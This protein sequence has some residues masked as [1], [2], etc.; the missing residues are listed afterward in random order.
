[1]F[2]AA[3]RRMEHLVGQTYARHPVRVLGVDPGLTR[4]GVGVV[5]GAPGRALTL[6][7]VGVIRTSADDDIATRLLAIETEIEQWLD[8]CQPDAVA[9]ERVFS[10]HNVRTVMGTAQAGAVAIVCAARRGLPVATHTPSEVKA[11]VTGNGR[12]GKDQVTTMV[13]KLLRISDPPRPPDAADALALAICHVWRGRAPMSTGVAARGQRDEGG[14]G[15]G[16][17]VIAHV[18]GTVAAVAPDGAVIEVGGVGMRVQCTPGTLATLRPGEP[19]QV[20]TSLVVREDSLTLYGFGSDD[21]RN[22]FELLQTASGVGPRLAL[23][24]LAVHTPDALRRAVST[25]DLGALTMVPGIG[26]K[27]AERIVLELR[28]RLGPPGESGAAGG[29]PGARSQRVPQWRDQVQSGLVNLGW[30]VRDADQAIAAL[31]EDGTISAANGETVDVATV[32]RA[33]LRKLSRP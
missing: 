24:M 4:C 14:W 30:P 19:A 5:D 9:V 11:A 17:G 16:W 23:A 15:G 6:V 22:V 32:L 8:A 27:G 18:R 7:R 20:A 26:R 28:D 10:Q 2:V 33:A 25:E 1:M 12:A 21:E 31:E 3:E 29:P 13:T